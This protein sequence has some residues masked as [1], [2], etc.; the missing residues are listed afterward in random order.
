MPALHCYYCMRYKIYSVLFSTV[1]LFF[2]INSIAQTKGQTSAVTK[3]KAPTLTKIKGFNEA[4]CIA[5]NKNLRI[6]KA[7][8]EN[9]RDFAEDFLIE[10]GGKIIGRQP[11]NGSTANFAVL[12]SDL[13][14]DGSIET[15]IVSHETTS[16]GLGVRYYAINIWSELEKKEYQAPLTFSVEEYGND[17]TFIRQPGTTGVLIFATNWISSDTLDKKSGTYLLGR[18]FRYDKGKLAPVNK[19]MLVR[20]LL[21]SFENERGK[22]FSDP[23]NYFTWTSPYSWFTNGKGREITADPEINGKAT[24][25]VNGTIVAIKEVK[26]K[27]DPADADSTEKSQTIYEIKADSGEHL[28]YLKSDEDEIKIK[29]P[30]AHQFMRFGL[31]AQKMI[32]PDGI[33]PEAVLHNLIG[34]NVQ[35]VSYQSEP[36]LNPIFVM[37]LTPA[38]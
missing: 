8:A 12:Q 5:V 4:H 10:R 28:T 23:P 30:Q 35:I 2:A 24:V 31:Q 29:F 7:I 17:G 9:E 18:W 27:Q 14:A 20:R 36:E 34:A 22:V 15:I 32:L 16:N 19:P 37:W 1:L 13:D 11:A 26:Y 3:F 6:C 38:K 25:A 33:T 21:S